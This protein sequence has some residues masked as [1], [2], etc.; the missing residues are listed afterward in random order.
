ML[1]ASLRIRHRLVQAQTAPSA[2]GRH[3]GRPTSGGRLSPGWGCL[4][5]IFPGVREL[6]LKARF[7]FKMSELGAVSRGFRRGEGECNTAIT[8]PCS[9]W[10]LCGVLPIGLSFR[11]LEFY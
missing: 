2:G 1:G 11:A 6:T 7:C 10:V 5:A 4:L 9:R 8:K 3:R